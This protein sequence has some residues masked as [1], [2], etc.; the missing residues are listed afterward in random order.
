MYLCRRKKPCEMKKYLWLWWA[1]CVGHIQAQEVLIKH[2]VSHLNVIE[3]KE[4]ER[5]IEVDI[6]LFKENLLPLQEKFYIPL[7][8]KPIIYGYTKRYLSYKW[9]GK[10]IGLSDYYFPLFDKKIRQYE[11]PYDIKYLAIVESALNP[12]ATSPVGAKGLWQFMPATGD[13]MGLKYNSYLNIF[14]DPMANTDSAMRYLK[15]LYERYNDWLLA[16]SAYNCGAGNVDKAI[17]RAKTN[18]YWQVRKYLPK[19][20]QAYVPTFLAI[21]YVFYNYR[22]YNIEPPIFK[23]QFTDF[24]IT[25]TT[26]AGSIKEVAEWYNTP[27]NVFRFANPQILTNY[28]PKGT[29][30]YALG[31]E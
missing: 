19:E 15:Q 2:D 5:P 14:Y 30:I 28:V 21:T 31:K 1:V 16:I 4:I 10:V 6:E 29:I 24:V 18:D 11:L 12:R 13:H 26:K 23:Y 20:T 9:I 3:G 27:E 8:A 22:D 7:E 17:R 25:T